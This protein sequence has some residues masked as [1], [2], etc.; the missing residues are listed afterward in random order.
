MTKYNNSE[1]V[2]EEFEEDQY[3]DFDLDDYT[4]KIK[5]QTIKKLLDGSR[6]YKGRSDKIYLKLTTTDLCSLFSISK[7][8]LY[9]WIKTNQLNPTNIRSIIEQFNKNCLNN[10]PN[11]Q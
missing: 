10:I 9:N 2:V 7:R 1:Y 5:E 4:K 8:T 6:N 11:K 3:K